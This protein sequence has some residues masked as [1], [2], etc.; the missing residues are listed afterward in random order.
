MKLFLRIVAFVMALAV[1]GIAPAAE[2]G[3]PDEAVA[4]VKKVIADMKKYGKD[5]VIKDIQNQ[6]PDYKDRDLYVSIGNLEG[7]N[8]ANGNNP[9]MA[10]KNIIDLKDADGK[11][12]TRERIDIVKSKGSGWQEYKW[13]DPITKEIQKKAMYVER[14]EDMT[15][16]CGV[17][18]N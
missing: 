17:Y 6:S 13:P 9:K 15:I 7:M 16:A 3:T 5:K 2:R 18:K 11:F 1:S 12:I 14:F 10:G 8:L 4:L